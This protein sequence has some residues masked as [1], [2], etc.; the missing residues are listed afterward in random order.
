[1]SGFALEYQGCGFVYSMSSAP[2]SWARRVKN[3]VLLEMAQSF[4]V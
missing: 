3:I 4:R 2:G 1:M